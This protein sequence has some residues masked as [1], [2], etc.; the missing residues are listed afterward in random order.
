MEILVSGGDWVVIDK[1][2]ACLALATRCIPSAA[3]ERERY[4]QWPRCECVSWYIV[5]RPVGPV[6]RALR[7]VIDLLY[8]VV[9]RPNPPSA[10]L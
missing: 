4:G 10:I 5:A 7:D 6:A 3:L 9:P 2:T 8:R 1:I